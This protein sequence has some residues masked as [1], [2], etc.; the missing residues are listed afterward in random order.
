MIFYLYYV[1]AKT[2]QQKVFL[3]SGIGFLVITAITGIAYIIIEFMPI[4]DHEQFR[5]LL[6]MHTFASLYGWNLCGLAIICR[7]DDF[8]VKLHSLPV[9]ILHWITVLLL[10]PA[11]KY[12]EGFA[13][14]AVVCYSTILYLILFSQ[15]VETDPSFHL[16]QNK[17]G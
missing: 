1:L 17:R 9:I 6:W 13:I 11:G 5:W 4:Y 7:F 15:K 3:T 8:P 2:L 16:L 10:A 12:Y 14:L